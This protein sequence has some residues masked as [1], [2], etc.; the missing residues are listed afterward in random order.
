MSRAIELHPGEQI[1]YRTATPLSWRMLQYGGGILFLMFGI[2]IWLLAGWGIHNYSDVVLTS[3]RVMLKKTGLFR[4]GHRSIPLDQ[5]FLSGSFW[6][7]VKQWVEL[8]LQNGETVKVLL[9]RPNVFLAR[10]KEAV[11]A[12]SS[13][14]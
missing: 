11:D 14:Q 3:Q 13:P 1:I 12:T 2:G 8:D 9:S 7:D 4:G 10:L 6:W 5:I